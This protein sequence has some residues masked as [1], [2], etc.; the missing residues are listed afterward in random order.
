MH[1]LVALLSYLI[2]TIPSAYLLVKFTTGKDIRDEGSGNV[3]ML[4]SY[5]TTGSKGLG[6]MVLI[7]DLA[8]GYGAVMLA[9]LIMDNEFFSAALAGI[10]VALGHNFNVFLKGKG[11]RGLA[12]AA[13]VSLAINPIT[14]I[15]WCLM[16]LTGYFTIRRNVHVGNISGTLG[17]A[18]LVATA[19]TMIVRWFMQLPCDP[20]SQHTMFVMLM[21]LQIFVRHLDPMRE[22]LDKWSDEPDV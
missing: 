2:G 1:I 12:T 11:G 19:P 18:V 8:K 20:L 14:L 6:A 4:N 10:L 21:C 5:E 22:L 17:A 9:R 7:L 15:F 3:G 13:G 16:W